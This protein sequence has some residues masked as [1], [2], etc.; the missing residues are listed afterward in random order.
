MN[1]FIKSSIY[2]LL[3]NLRSCQRWLYKNFYAKNDPYNFIALGPLDCKIEIIEKEYVPN[4]DFPK[5]SIITP[6]LNEAKNILKVFEAIEKQTLYPS[7]WIIIDGGST[8]GTIKKIEEYK[9]SSKFNITLLH[10]KIR[11]IGHQRNLGIK[12]A[13]NN[14]LVNIDAGTFPDK[15]YLANVI[16]PFYKHPNLDLVSGVHYATNKT[17]HSKHISTTNHFKEKQNPYGNCLVYMKDIAEASGFFPEYLT[18]AGED[19]F[20]CYKYKKLSKHWIFN[21]AAW[22]SWEIPHST[23]SFLAKSKNYMSAN[24]ENGLWPY[25]Y[26]QYFA[27]HISKFLLST[28]LRSIFLDF[29]RK[30]AKIEIEK[31]NIKGICVIHSEYMI[32]DPESKELVKKVKQ[33]IAKNYKVFFVNRNY[34]KS[35][36][37]KLVFLDLDHSL[38]H[39]V[40]KKDFSMRQLEQKYG[41]F[42]KKNTIVKEI[43]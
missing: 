31:R 16:G 12:A 21:K 40:H 23:E 19:T 30:Q 20:F 39:L 11:N 6:V 24:F 27:G 3:R 36:A 28:L 5:F 38:L 4:K 34:S 33:Y 7:E 22:T 29:S 32:T 41:D 15:N 13:K 26:H 2:K 18:Y 8:D 9:N 35:H 17:S 25:L 37:K 10:S 42:A 43:L 14:I 1:N